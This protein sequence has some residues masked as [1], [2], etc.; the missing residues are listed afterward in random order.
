MA[1]HISNGNLHIEKLQIKSN[2]EIA[3]LSNSFSSMLDSLQY[4]AQVIQF[5]AEGDL[6]QNIMKASEHDQLGQSLIEMSS[7][8]NTLMNEIKQT[9]VEVANGAENVSNAGQLLSQGAVEQASSLEEITSS[10]NS[11]NQKSKDNAVNAVEASNLAKLASEKTTIGNNNMNNLLAAMDRISES[12]NNISSVVKV[13]DDIAFQINLLALNANVEAA[14]AGKY[15]KGFA[16][17]ADEVRNLA[18]R[19]AEAAK[20]TSEM[21]EITGRNVL[22]GKKTAEQTS[23]QLKEI[24][25][26]IIKVSHVLSEIASSSGEQ[27]QGV[28]QINA[29]LEQIDSVTQSNSSSAE[30]SASA[31]EELAAQALGLKSLI[32]RFKLAQLRSEN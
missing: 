19:S 11:I 18:I 5:V 16:V 31:G 4:K 23:E 10:L 17:V 26:E 30:E 22:D 27:A 14:R 9:V 1:N 28:D 6:S 15:G 3:M 12:S 7:S 8:L 13:I 2:D 29:G 24:L 32:D 21:M 20:E 25:N